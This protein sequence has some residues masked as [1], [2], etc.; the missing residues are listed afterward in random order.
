DGPDVESVDWWAVTQAAQ[1]LGAN[2][3]RLV[4]LQDTD[5]AIRWCLD[6][7]R[8]HSGVASLSYFEVAVMLGHRDR[9]GTAG[10][11]L[12][13]NDLLLA[14]EKLQA[15]VAVKADAEKKAAEAARKAEEVRVAEERKAAEEAASAEGEKAVAIRANA[16]SEAEDVGDQDEWDAGGAA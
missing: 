14:V 13:W 12:E 16:S 3:R 2:T 8:S 5:E 6:M 15:A 7:S 11:R 9:K 1:L 10:A 4:A